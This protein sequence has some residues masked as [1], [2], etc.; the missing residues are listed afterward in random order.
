MKTPFGDLTYC[1]NIHPGEKWD[2]HFAALRASVPYVRQQLAPGKAFAL[3]L[4]LAN[5]ASIELSKPDRLAEFKTW[6]EEQDIFVPIING[7]PYGG[8]HDTVVKDQVH[9]P[10]WTTIERRDY[11]IR[12]FDIVA[13]LLPEGKDGGVSTPPLSYRL[14]WKDVAER[15]KATEVATGQ[16]LEVLD[17][18]IELKSQT[19]KSLHLDIE[20]EPD[21]LLD[22]VGDFIAW[23]RDILLP[24]GIKYLINKYSFAAEKARETIIEHIQLCYDI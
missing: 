1:S 9:T 19:G 12:L 4:R 10:D 14:W 24:N 8:F 16:I 5:E 20:P 11:T 13:Q 3:G 2:D 17:H 21:G 18:L 23:Y 22:N 6:L 15:N 7:F